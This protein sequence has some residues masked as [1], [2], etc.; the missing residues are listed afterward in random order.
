MIIVYIFMEGDRFISTTSFA[1]VKRKLFY[2]SSTLME[3]YESF[4]NKYF[5]ILE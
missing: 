1:Q 5:K 4:L 3:K 2:N